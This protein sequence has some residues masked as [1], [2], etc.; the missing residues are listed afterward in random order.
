MIPML[1]HSPFVA[2]SSRV[3]RSF[4]AAPF[5]KETVI[6]QHSGEMRAPVRVRVWA[7]WLVVG[8]LIAAAVLGAAF[9]L[10]GDQAAIS[11]RAW[12]T[13]LLAAAFA[14][15]VVLDVA[16]GTGPNRWYF[17]ASISI[18]AVLFVVGLLKTWGGFFQPDDT[19]DP[20]VWGRQFGAFLAIV[21]LLRVSLLISQ[22]YGPQFAVRRP[23]RVTR[24][25]AS[26]ALVLLWVT[27]VMLV[28]PLALP[29]AEWDDVGSRLVGAGALMTAVLMLIP[30]VLLAFEPREPKPYPPTPQPH[31][32][33]FPPPPPAL[34]GTPGFPATH[35]LEPP[36]QPPVQPH[37]QPP[38]EG[39]WVQPT[40]PQAP[41]QPS[42]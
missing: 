21:V 33:G 42:S 1:R 29:A 25:L 2:A 14:G 5:L 22:T 23:L 19:T 40:P 9:I 26:L 17:P 27:T 41:G 34:S 11:A 36:A 32:Y 18:D 10:L 12:L 38:G 31:G 35:H 15:T 13:L 24:V 8:V 39:E 16:V 37:M 7:L 3:R 28:L 20:A 4:S 30:V 6:D